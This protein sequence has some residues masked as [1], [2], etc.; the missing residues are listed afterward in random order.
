MIQELKIKNFISFKEEVKFSFEASK[1]TFA[2]SSQVVK[3]N[4]NTRL[5]RFAVV[6]GYNA[7]GKTNLLKAFKFLKDFWFKKQSDAYDGTNVKPFKLDQSSE[8]NPSTFD[9]IFFVEG[10]KYRYQLE[11]NQ[12]VVLLERLSYYK[13]SQPIKLFERTLESGQTAISF[14]SNLKVSKAIKDNITLLCLNNMSFFAAREQLNAKIPLID[15]VKEWLRR[16]F[17]ETITPSTDLTLYAQRKLSNDNDLKKYIIDFL[18]E[19][20]FNI[21]D[22]SSETVENALPKEILDLVLKIKELS[23]IDKSKLSDKKTIQKIRTD[24]YHTVERNGESETYP[25]SL[26]DKEESNGT[27]RTFG[28]ETAIHSALK[29][30]AFLAID[31]IETSFHPYLLEKIL[32]EFLRSKSQ[33]QLLVSTHNDGLLDLVNDLIREDCVWF[34]EKQKS[35]ITD[36]Y[37]LNDFRGLKNL[38]SIRK[39][40]RNKRFGATMGSSWK[41]EI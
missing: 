33:S 13:S 28:I 12:S 20:D 38:I 21:S 35:G 9:L 1:D 3:V 36:L 22:I 37:K 6:Y 18:H 27:V 5:L 26:D 10:I 15:D 14:G 25:L 29:R 31:E 16:K 8:K 24:F 17:M 7:S 4:E 41:K 40:Y 39:A 11:L 30:N 34:T 32:Y 23:T 19:A 2:E